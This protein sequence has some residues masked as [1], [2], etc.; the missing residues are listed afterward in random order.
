MDF[1]LRLKFLRIALTVFGLIFVFAVGPLMLSLWPSGWAWGAE[2]G[3]SHYSLMIIAI[4]AVL[5]IF[6]LLAARKPR[7]YGAIVWFTVWSSVLHGAVMA[8]QAYVDPAERGHFL[9]DI[10]G[11][12]IVA[13]VLAYLMP[14]DAQFAGDGI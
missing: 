6:L 14:R 13:A 5:G 4:Y 3:H 10:P 1:G 9:G 8:I 7:Q 11:I 12:L 2:H